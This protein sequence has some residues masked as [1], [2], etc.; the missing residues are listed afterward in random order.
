VFVEERGWER[1]RQ[2]GREEEKYMHR[3]RCMNA[4]TQLTGAHQN[5][6]SCLGRE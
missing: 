1:E 3:L 2:G 6:R 5:E 4:Q